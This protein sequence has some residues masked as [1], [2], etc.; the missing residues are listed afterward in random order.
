MRI[1]V[2]GA[3]PAGLYFALLAKKAQPSH[4]ITVIERNPRD[5]TYGWG[6]VFSEE[7]LGA[8]READRQ[9]FDEITETFAKWT[10]IDVRYRGETVRSRGHAFS[11]IARKRLLEILQ[12][13]C[14]ELGVELSF[15]RELADVSQFGRPDL[16]VGADGVNSLVRRTHEVVFKPSLDVHRTKYAWFGADLVFKAFTFI[17]R[18]TEHGLF[19]VHGYPVDA[20]TSTFIVECPEPVWRRAGLDGAS[21][22]DSVAFCQK[23]FAQDLQGHSL[24]SNRSVWMSFVTVKCE[25]WHHGNMVLLGDAA[26]TAHFTIGSGTKLAMEDAISLAEALERKAGDLSAAL[27]EYEMERQPVV[28]RFQQAAT[29]S[30]AYFEGVSRYRSFEPVQFAFNLLTRSG[31]ITHLEL[32][33]RD[34]DLVGRVDGWFAATARG[35]TL[36]DGAHALVAPPPMFSPFALRGIIAPN[37]VAL[38]SPG[39]DDAVDGSPGP[40]AAEQ[41]IEAVKTGAGVVLTEFVAVSPDG[42][43][44]PGSAGLWREDQGEA[45]AG[46]VE[47]VRAHGKAILALQ[48]GH[49]GRRGATRSRRQGVDRPLREGGWPLVSASAIPYAPRGQV[50]KEIDRADMDGVRERFVGSARMAA[51]AGFDLLELNF[52]HGYL[53][54]SFISPLSN[55]RADEYGGSLENRIRFPLEILEAVRAAWP[56]ERPLAVSLSVTDWARGGLDAGDGVAAAKMLKERGCDLIQVQAGQTTMRASPVYGRMFLASYSD[57]VRNEVGVPTLVGGN[58]TTRDEVNTLL[59]AGRADLCVLTSVLH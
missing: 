48:L 28:D 8:L 20:E 38:A 57:R 52:A 30:A 59:A 46:I 15:E 21:E 23:L 1:V 2:V 43:I 3:G 35:A 33:R 54:A 29:E 11:A 55:R 13:R 34:P 5:A 24:L 42:R 25:T 39:E 45:W 6:V 53:P 4:R 51:L 37:R 7:T 36:D 12:G 17:F 22:E 16:V 14:A 10:A 27:T 40:E 19:Q 41:L 58:I 44:T 26:H 49:A 56:E 18:E 31:R 32:Q 9:T 50:P 47:R